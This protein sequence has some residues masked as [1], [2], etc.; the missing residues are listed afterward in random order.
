MSIESADSKDVLDSFAGHSEIESGHGNDGLSI[1]DVNF[2][3]AQQFMS[4]HKKDQNQDQTIDALAQLI[5]ALPEY[6]NYDQAV[7]V[8]DF[9]SGMN[10]ASEENIDRATQVLSNMVD[11]SAIDF[12]SQQTVEASGVAAKV[13]SSLETALSPHIGR[14]EMTGANNS[15]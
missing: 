5:D 3:F 1:G 11:P 2:E 15:M 13:R 14:L 12:L 7:Q 10:K 8:V 4:D 6:M 9:L